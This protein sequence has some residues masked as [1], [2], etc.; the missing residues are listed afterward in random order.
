MI[1]KIYLGR[2]LLSETVRQIIT[3]KDVVN[4]YTQSIVTNKGT[5]TFTRNANNIIT[6]V[7]KS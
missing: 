2:L 1:T 5:Y 7:V 6:G 4:N 3:S